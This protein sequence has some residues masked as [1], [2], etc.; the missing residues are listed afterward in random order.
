VVAALVPWLGFAIQ[1]GFVSQSALLAVL[2][3]VLIQFA[4]LVVFSVPD[5]SGDMAVGKSTLCVRIGPLHTGRTHQAAVVLA[6][7]TLPLL[8]QDRRLS[9]AATAVSFTLPL[10]LVQLRAVERGELLQPQAWPRIAFT[11]VALT[12]VTTVAELVGLVLGG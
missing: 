12:F 8:W 10:A 6:Y 5:R 9:A 1:T 7:L 3:L 2:P 11:A 4:M